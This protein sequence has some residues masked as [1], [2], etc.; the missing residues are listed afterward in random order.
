M[1]GEKRRD[2]G[3]EEG[4]AINHYASLSIAQGLDFPSKNGANMHVHTS[5]RSI[6][7]RGGGPAPGAP[8][9]PPPPHT[10]TPLNQWTEDSIVN[11]Y[12]VQCVHAS[13]N[14]NG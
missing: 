11:L 10:H 4:K 9:P 14:S 2:R 13:V 6:T 5:V 8:P 1:M 12:D 3:I 7:L